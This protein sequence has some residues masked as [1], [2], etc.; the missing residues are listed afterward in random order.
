MANDDDTALVLLAKAGDK[1]AF[2]ILVDRHRP[3]ALRIAGRM[4]ANPDVARELGAGGAA[5]RLPVAG[6]TA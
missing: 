3:M 5:A 4:T 6:Q 1:E 2:G